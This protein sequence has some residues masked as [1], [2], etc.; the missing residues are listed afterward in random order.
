[1]GAVLGA[2]VGMSAGVGEAVSTVYAQSP[3]AGRAG[4]GVALWGSS[5]VSMAAVRAR[6]ADASVRSFLVRQ[7]LTTMG[8]VTVW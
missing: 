8:V 6:L 1:M 3:I 5:G 7:Q 4:G 2:F